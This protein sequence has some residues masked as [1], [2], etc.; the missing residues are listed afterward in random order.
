MI[1]EWVYTSKDQGGHNTNLQIIWRRSGVWGKKEHRET[2]MHHI[3][4][5]KPE[6]TKQDVGS[7]ARVGVLRQASAGARAR[8]LHP[9]TAASP[10]NGAV[11]TPDR[12]VFTAQLT[13]EPQKRECKTSN[14]RKK[15]APARPTHN[16]AMTRRKGP[17]AA[18]GH[19]TLSGPRRSSP[20]RASAQ[21]RG[22]S[23][24]LQFPLPGCAG[25]EN[26]E[27]STERGERKSDLG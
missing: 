11:H 25:F 18:G 9:T 20:H 12:H 15:P 8:H 26:P 23:S 4:T 27:E 1:G 19:R 5:F 21:P 7:S 6:E 14:A 13:G 17:Q 2:A 10:L 3:Q 16:L 22:R 24:Y